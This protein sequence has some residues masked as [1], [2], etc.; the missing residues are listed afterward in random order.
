MI[1]INNWI[2]DTEDDVDHGVFEPGTFLKSG[3]QIA[4]ILIEKSESVGQAI[5]RLQYYIN[6]GGKDVANL[7]QL[8][9]AMELLHT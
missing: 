1:T 9:L 5:K 6:R 8:N 7:D 2:K 3:N 4:K